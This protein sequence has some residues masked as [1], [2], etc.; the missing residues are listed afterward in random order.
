MGELV[1]VA[2]SDDRIGIVGPKIYC[3]DHEGKTNVVESYNWK[4]S[5]WRQSVYYAL[6]GAEDSGQYDQTVEV[7]WVSGCASLIKRETIK[8]LSLL[9]TDYFTGYDD[10]EYGIRASKHGIKMMCVPAAKVWHKR[11]VSIKKLYKVPMLDI[12]D[13]FTFINKNFPK[14]VYIYRLILFFSLT[15]I[16]WG[17]NYLVK[18]RDKERLVKYISALKKFLAKNVL[19]QDT[20]RH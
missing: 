20:E 4:I 3:Y 13:Y 16:R 18:Y 7:D 12:S 17:I 6:G 10:V 19:K 2:E 11:S 1:K 9:N 15:S 14:H 5:W 8:R